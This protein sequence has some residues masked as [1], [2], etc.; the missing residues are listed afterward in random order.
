MAAGS[1]RRTHA[2]QSSPPHLSCFLF[3]IYHQ[4][5]NSR[6][7]AD[8]WSVCWKLPCQNRTHMSRDGDTL[9]FKKSNKIRNSLLPLT[10]SQQH[11]VMCGRDLKTDNTAT[12]HQ[13]T[14]NMPLTCHNN[15]A[16][17]LQQHR[18]N[19]PYNTP[20][21]HPHHTNKMSTSQRHASNIKSTVRQQHTKNLST[22]S[23]QHINNMATT[24]KQHANN[25]TECQRH[26]VD[27]STTR[28]RHI[29]NIWQNVTNTPTTCHSHII[30]TPACPQNVINVPIERQQRSL[31]CDWR[32]ETDTK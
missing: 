32:I 29:N 18:N 26:V 6:W 3:Q 25:T 7:T 4:R 30:S 23:Q 24:L 21:L 13:H 31:C 10:S 17:T 28:L 14:N 19:T 22:I 5:R 16:M 12:T 8:R 27:M 2:C 20:V 9:T 11:T 15:T 1:G